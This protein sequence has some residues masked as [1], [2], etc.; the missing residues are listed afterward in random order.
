MNQA[1][2][3]RASYVMFVNAELR[4]MFWA[5]FGA[6]HTFDFYGPCRIVIWVRAHTKMCKIQTSPCVGMFPTV[7]RI[8][9]DLVCARRPLIS[10]DTGA[11]TQGLQAFFNISG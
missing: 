4:P 7:A 5:G 3:I 11:E 9:G 2:Q 10:L 6:L 1:H 8:K